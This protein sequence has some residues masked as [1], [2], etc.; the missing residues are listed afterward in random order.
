MQTGDSAAIGQRIKLQRERAGM[1]RRVLAELVGKSLEWMKSVELGR[2]QNPPSLNLLL[3]IAHALDLK[4]L[5]DLTG[6]GYAVSVNVFA[7][8]RHVALDEVQSALTDFRIGSPD[9]A[10]TTAHLAERLRRGWEIRHSSPDHRTQLGLLLP[11]LIRDAQAAARAYGDD[12]RDARRIL[13]GV[14]QLTDFFVAYQPAAELV[15]MVADRG[16]SEGFE[17]DDPY[18]IACSAWAMVQ[19]LRDSGR[20]EEAIGLARDAS[21]RLR[22][23]IDKDGTSDDWRGIFGA[24]EAEVAYV[25]ARRGHYGEAWAGWEAADKVA[26]RLGPTYRH[27]QT[28]F[29]T[30]VMG[31]HAVTLGV[32]LQRAGEAIEA[33]RKF[34]ADNIISVPRRARH[35]IEVARAHAQRDQGTATLALLTKAESTAPE[36]IK[37]NR[38][39][40]E[41]L[42]ELQRNPPSGMRQDVENLSRRVGVAA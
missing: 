19:A 26:R 27:I 2:L 31:A 30:A 13:A 6:D 3:Q 8:E 9:K 15:W 41:M 16:L 17:S 29:S 32:E 21:A 22:P 4:D 24:L 35:F 14:Y 28:S 25:Y 5:A 36:T 38:F 23:Y 1:P 34:D 37:Y 12:R 40:R 20:W 11:N 42:L 33:S 39:A 10:I 7:G 18:V